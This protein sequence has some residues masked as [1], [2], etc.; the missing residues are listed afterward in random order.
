MWITCIRTRHKHTTKMK[1][2][3]S[4]W[5]TSTQGRMVNDNTLVK[6]INV[7]WR[8]KNGEMIKEHT[9]H[10]KMMDIR[11]HNAKRHTTHWE[12]HIA[13]AYKWV[14]QR[15]RK[16]VNGQRRST[17][18]C[19]ELTKGQI[20]H[21]WNSRDCSLVNWCM[22]CRVQNTHTHTH[23]KCTRFL[24]GKQVQITFLPVFR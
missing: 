23:L 12:T 1:V 4:G 24:A 8:I 21:T 13:S 10:F 15:S 17:K 14:S 22:S 19:P 9:R 16:A 5:G 11:K 2:R 20:K 3:K 6:N 7:E 18:A